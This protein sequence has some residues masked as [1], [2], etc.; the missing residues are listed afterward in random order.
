MVKALLTA[1]ERPVLLAVR[2]FDPGRLMLRLLNV[3]TPEAFV[4]CVKVPERDPVPVVNAKVIGTPATAM[5]FPL[6]S[7]SCTV[8]GG[9]MMAPVSASLGC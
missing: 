1:E 6:L 2:F 9:L 5:L 4:F 8:T 7:R 3:D